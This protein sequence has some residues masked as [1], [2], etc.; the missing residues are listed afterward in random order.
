MKVLLL[1]SLPPPPGGVTS[2]VANLMRALR[3]KKHRAYVISPMALLLRWDIAH[4]HYTRPWKRLAGVLV[5]KLWARRVM[6]TIHNGRVDDLGWT[7][8]LSYR[9]ADRIVLLN[10]DAHRKVRD[11][12]CGDRALLLGNY[13]RE[14]MTPRSDPILE[15]SAGRH[16][17]VYAYDRVAHEGR[18]IYGVD[19][20]LEN[21]DA[22][23]GDWTLVL[24]D[25]KNR[26]GAEAA[27]AGSRVRHVAEP[28]NFPK[29]L[30]DVD[31]YLRPTS[32]DGASVA[33][34]EAL[35]VGTAVVASDAV[36]RPEVVFTHRWN[37]ADDYRRAIAEAIAAADTP[38]RQPGVA[39]YLDACQDVLARR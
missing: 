34:Q 9:L 17:M 38:Y 21:L 36:A 30:E 28:V 37:D 5:G 7:D 19:F 35:C 1:G 20:V 22:L 27:A 14:G 15:M 6:A 33:V 16:A 24:V 12:H 29:L 4:V 8:R 26:Y 39:E 2:S 23:P 32:T 25:P 13:Y 11:R 10:P 18:D 31:L 3:V